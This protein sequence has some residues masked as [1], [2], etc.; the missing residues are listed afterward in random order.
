ME[1]KGFK[2]PPGKKGIVGSKARLEDL[3]VADF[4]KTVIKG[5][6]F[7]GEGKARL[8][9]VARSNWREN[10]PRGNLRL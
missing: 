4:S 9:W 1:K 7:V 2:E 8:G 5:M 3:H 10:S 6:Y